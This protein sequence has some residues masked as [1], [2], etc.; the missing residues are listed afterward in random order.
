M[1]RATRLPMVAMALGMSLAAAF[2]AMAQQQAP[3]P[4]PDA[5]VRKMI[6]LGLRNIDKAVCDGFNA[7]AAATDAELKDPPISVEQARAAVLV[8]GRS[9]MAKW[10]G[11]DA[12]RR[13]VLPLLTQLRRSKQYNERQLA[14]MAVIHGIQQSIIS[15]QLKAKGECDAAMRSKLDAQLP[16]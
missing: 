8:G 14:L 6:E 12:E 13:S 11:L 7:C 16:R 15:E 1:Q 10:C 3:S 9:A 2:G 4:I 5:V